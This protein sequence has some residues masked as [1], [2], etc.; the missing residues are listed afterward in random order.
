MRDSPVPI[1]H[2]IAEALRNAIAVG[3]LKPGAGLPPI[4]EAAE[5]WDVNLHTVRKAYGE[6]AR[7]GLVIV[8]RQGSRVSPG[9]RGE[10]GAGSLDALIGTFVRRGY[11]RFGLTQLQLGQ[12]LLKRAA[13]AAPVPVHFVECSLHQAEGHCREI[14]EAWRVEASP[15]VLG[16]MTE[17]PTGVVIS[18]Y[19]HYNDIRQRWPDRIDDVRFVAIAPDAAL[20]R[21]LPAHAGGRQRLVVCELEESK[22]VNIAADLSV[23]L[24]SDRYELEPCVLPSPSALPPRGGGEVLLAAPRVWGAMT[25]D[26]RAGV[27]LIRYRLRSYELEAL[28]ESFGWR[29]WQEEGVA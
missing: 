20:W 24:P 4:R 2:Q 21:Q 29:R 9:D 13:A 7:E 10:A 11:E 26:A 28:G 27:V 17:L 25:E 18:T 15:V 19:F 3:S 5:Q 16:E 22:A 12:L 1:Y 6:L 8:D 23:L 14:M